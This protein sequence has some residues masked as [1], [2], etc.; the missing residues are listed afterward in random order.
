MLIFEE[1]TKNT[2]EDRSTTIKPNDHQSHCCKDQCCDSKCD[3]CLE[4]DWDDDDEEEED[5]WE[6]VITS[7]MKDK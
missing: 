6:E 2:G 4:L 3:E 7:N 1:P 5:D